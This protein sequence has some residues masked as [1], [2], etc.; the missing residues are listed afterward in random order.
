MPIFIDNVVHHAIQQKKFRY[1][2]RFIQIN[3]DSKLK[4]EFIEESRMSSSSSE[5][6]GGGGLN[7]FN[8]MSM[9]MLS[10]Q[11]I[12]NIVNTSNNNK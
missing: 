8:F 2:Q 4:M 7:M 6:A 9:I 3:V 12:V 11:M 5:C 10:A 1:L